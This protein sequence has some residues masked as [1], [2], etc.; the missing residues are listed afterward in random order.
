MRNIFILFIFLGLIVSCKN[1]DTQLDGQV[2]LTLLNDSLVFS[3][4]NI[5][6]YEITNNSNEKLLFFVRDKEMMGFLELGLNIEQEGTSI[7]GS[8]GI[9]DFAEGSI[10][11]KC[12]G[13]NYLQM[14]E[15]YSAIVNNSLN[16][17]EL[18]FYMNYEDK[19][20]VISPGES[21]E[22]RTIVKLPIIERGASVYSYDLKKDSIYSLALTYSVKRN[23]FGELPNFEKENL[24]RNNIR[25][26][27]GELT[28]N[29]VK[30]VYVATP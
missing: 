17:K 11:D 15:R 22:F 21:W 29:K 3:G 12:E 18:D 6:R 5:L 8:N 16:A 27:E 2:E 14:R 24:K 28:S 4:T 19:H 20:I 23:D 30:L 10:E 1:R 13:Y 7:K 25:L 9:R 26:F